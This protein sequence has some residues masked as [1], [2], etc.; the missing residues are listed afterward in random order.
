MKPRKKPVHTERRGKSVE[1]VGVKPRVTGG[2]EGPLPL[3]RGSA[4]APAPLFSA[5]QIESPGEGYRKIDQGRSLVAAALCRLLFK[6][7]TSRS[8][9]DRRASI[10]LTR[11]EVTG[12]ISPEQIALVKKHFKPTPRWKRFLRW[13]VNPAK[14]L[15]EKFVQTRVGCLLRNL[16]ARIKYGRKRYFS[17]LEV[18]KREQ[19]VRAKK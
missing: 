4:V 15:R 13:A 3:P 8:T 19:K 1:H 5:W 7:T 11:F 14:I 18:V 12:W 9:I 6:K 2:K 17:P 10:G 16:K